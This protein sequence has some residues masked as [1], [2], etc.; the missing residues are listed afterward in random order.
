M[1]AASKTPYASPSPRTV[2]RSVT[3]VTAVVTAITMSA[4]G[5]AP[6]PLYH[7]YQEHFLLTPFMITIIFAT[8]VLCLL[9]ALLTVG[10]LSDYVGRR[11]SILAALALNVAAM[12]VFMTAGS[13]AALIGARAI[14][15]FATGLA[16]TTLAATILDT[17]NERAPLLNSITVFVG[18][19]VGTLGAGAL[20]TFAPA[21]DQLV[22][23]VLLLL[24]LVEA[25]ILWFMPETAT[26]KPGALGSLLPHVHV[27]KVAR[28]TFAAVSPVNIAAW[29]L[30]GFYFS[31]MP[32]VVR[33]ATGTELPILGGLVVASLTFTAAVA[34]AP[35]AFCGEHVRPRYRHVD[36][37]C[38]VNA[39]WCRE[40]ER[41]HHAVRD[42]CQR[43]GFWHGLFGNASKL[44]AV[45]STG[46]ARGAPGRLL[47]RGVPFIQPSGAR[48]RLPC[49]CHRS[50]ADCRFLRRRGDPFGSYFVDPEDR[51]SPWE[52]V[53]Q[54]GRSQRRDQATSNGFRHSSPRRARDVRTAAARTY[55]SSRCG[56]SRRA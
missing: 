3:T 37:W 11:P 26:T 16:L 53:T 55:M 13:A 35:Q 10:S 6:T 38:D 52:L 50:N 21:P 27:P 46:Q 1:S 24:S 19:S 5:A 15:G 30:G 7:Q 14:Q 2:S 48:G 34:V 31:L 47:R 49:T 51:P 8:Y 45:R 39:R 32:S 41:G 22:F 9:F 23:A 17:D 12:I 43:C 28:A 33:A 54:G 40:S 29:A 36:D 56:S 44:A 42:G 4:S 20:V 25:L 18:L